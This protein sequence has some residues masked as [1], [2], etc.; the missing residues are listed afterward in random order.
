MVRAMRRV[1]AVCLAVLIAGCGG[2]GG[3]EDKNCGD[4]AYQQDAQAW[5]NSH[6]NS[7]LDRD[8]DG[9]AC[10]SLPRR[11]SG[12]G[13]GSASG[14]SESLPSVMVFDLSG[15]VASIRNTGSQ[16]VRTSVTADSESD[17]ILTGTSLLGGQ[18][19]LDGPSGREY[20]LDYGGPEG[21]PSHNVL[22]L[23]T[24][25]AWPT[26]S[27]ATS[28]S[29]A[30]GGTY[31][32][33]GQ[34]C[35]ASGCDVT[36]G[37]FSVNTTSLTIAVCTAGPIT[38]CTSGVQ[39]YSFESSL[40]VTGMPGVYRFRSA[41]DR[42]GFIAFGTSVQGAIGISILSQDASPAR[43]SAFAARTSWTYK[44]TDSPSAPFHAISPILTSLSG[45]ASGLGAFAINDAPMPGFFTR[46]SNPSSL[47][48]VAVA[49]AR[50]LT[51]NGGYYTLWVN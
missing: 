34:R 22:R 10:E 11:P 51:Y 7:D 31:N 48:M 5:H 25:Y 39:R 23:E 16:Y 50:V 4:F 37:Q 36:Y 20:V 12:G 19:A 8:G 45:D 32:F 30:L 44:I 24:A 3:D 35:L 33:M 42:T 40:P 49:P 18:F 2:G 14:S 15:Q 6:P 1:G 9:I 46:S 43:I 38:S 29:S 17:G 26:S 28:L 13:S 21:Y 47:N 27:V 41:D